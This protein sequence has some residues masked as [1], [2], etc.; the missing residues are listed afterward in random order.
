MGKNAM[1]CPKLPSRKLPLHAKAGDM[2]GALVS[3]AAITARCGRH[4]F[5]LVELGCR[6]CG[7]G[8][9]GMG[10]GLLTYQ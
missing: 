6:I 2:I 8:G 10:K 4:S 7:K 1:R 5:C 3:S 9:G